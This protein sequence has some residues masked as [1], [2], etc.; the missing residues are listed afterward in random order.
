M[1]G[2]S[3][4]PRSVLPE[5]IYARAIAPI[6]NAVDNELIQSNRKLRHLSTTILPQCVEKATSFLSGYCIHDPR[7]SNCMTDFSMKSISVCIEPKTH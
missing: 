2:Y 6:R 3:K 4:T 5:V 7:F 1:H